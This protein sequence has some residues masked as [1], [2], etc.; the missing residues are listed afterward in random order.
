MYYTDERGKRLIDFGCVWNLSILNGSILGDIMG[1]W[2]CYR[3]NGNSIVDYMMV[4]HELRERV[5]FMKILDLTDHSDHRPVLCRLRTSSTSSGAISE[6]KACLFEEKP[7][8]FKWQAS[9]Q[10]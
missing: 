7:L 8:G 10:E 5:S 4:S 3:Y 1:D 6:N 9:N 2:T